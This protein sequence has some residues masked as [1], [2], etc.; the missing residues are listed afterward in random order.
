MKNN[1]DRDNLTAA[2]MQLNAV[3]NTAAVQSELESDREEFPAEKECDLDIIHSAVKF[4]DELQK[5]LFS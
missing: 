3:L 4:R 1:I 2:Y 5:Y